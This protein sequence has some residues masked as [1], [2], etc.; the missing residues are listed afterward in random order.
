MDDVSSDTAYTE[1]GNV[2][3]A[4][5]MSF[6]YQIASGMVRLTVFHDLA[7]SNCD[8]KGSGMHK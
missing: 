3:P 1:L 2:S 8:H 6:A 4:D 7:I 5:L